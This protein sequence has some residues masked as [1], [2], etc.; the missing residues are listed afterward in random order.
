[1]PEKL[2]EVTVVDCYGRRRTIQVNAKS[3][4]YA[5]CAYYARTRANPTDNLPQSN[6]STVYEVKIVGENQ[7]F[8]VNH[9]KMM[10]WANREA[11]RNA[12][13]RQG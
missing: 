7:V 10:E 3:T 6:D 9:R 1:M 4:Y 8:R 13:R 11:S 2:C 5:A 12:R